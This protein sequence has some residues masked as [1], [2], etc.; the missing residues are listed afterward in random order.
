MTRINDPVSG[1]IDWPGLRQRIAK[2]FESSRETIEPSSHRAKK[3][4]EERARKL[5]LS[6]DADQPELKTVE[7]LTFKLGREQYALETRFARE[8]IR[9]ADFAVIPGAPQYMIGVTNLRGDILPVFDL[10]LLF[11]LT[12]RGLMDRSRVIVL[13]AANPEFGI[14]ADS[15][16]E[17]SRASLEELLPNQVFDEERA[18][19][20]VRG[21][22]R[23]AMIVLDGDALLSDQRLFIDASA[24]TIP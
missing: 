20:C 1:D 22:T 16:Q 3:I 18:R 19:E 17:V 13:G 10:M 9:L 11:G 14:I 8:V 21:V 12:A 15:V 23:D 4:L 5:A 6:P 2:T 7:V 24:S